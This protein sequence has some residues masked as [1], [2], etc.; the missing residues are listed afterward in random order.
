VNKLTAELHRRHWFARFGALMDGSAWMMIIPC[1]ALLHFI[2]P[3]D[4]KVMNVWLLR[5]PI[6]IGFVI[7]LSRI[8]FPTVRVTEL[9]ADVKAGNVGSSI[10]IAGLM[11]FLGLL[12]LTATMWTK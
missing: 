12:V 4:A 6:I 8:F 5:L 3:L 1:E 9:M 10:V 7:I 11:I 2:D